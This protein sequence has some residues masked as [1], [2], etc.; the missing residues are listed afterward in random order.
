M[1]KKGTLW[2]LRVAVDGLGEAGKEWYTRFPRKPV[3]KYKWS[4]VTRFPGRAVAKYPERNVARFLK[5]PAT[6]FPRKT[7][8][9]ISAWLISIGVIRSKTDPNGKLV[10]MLALYVDDV[11]HAGSARSKSAKK[12]G[13]KAAGSRKMMKKRAKK[14]TKKSSGTVQTEKGVKLMKK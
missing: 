9:T 1:R 4:P 6:K 2:K 8:E 3:A 5:K 11:L 12:V 10:G 7:A 13:R 14:L